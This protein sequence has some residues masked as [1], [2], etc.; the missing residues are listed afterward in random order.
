[1]TTATAQIIVMGLF[2][3]ALALFA[4]WLEVNQDPEEKE[5]LEK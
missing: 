3:V 5:G 4:L 1:M 2:V